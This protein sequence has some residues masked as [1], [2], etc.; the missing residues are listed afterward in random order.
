[1]RNLAAPGGHGQRH[2][3]RTADPSGSPLSA[4][5]INSVSRSG[6]MKVALVVLTAGTVTTA[7]SAPDGE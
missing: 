4:V 5:V 7:D 1:M 3:R 2:L 6:P